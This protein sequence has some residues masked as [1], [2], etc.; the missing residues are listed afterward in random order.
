[1]SARS[2]R[3][4]KHLAIRSE[5]APTYIIA[6][7][8]IIGE[9]IFDARGASGAELVKRTKATRTRGKTQAG[10]RAPQRKNKRRD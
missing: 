1:M 9:F 4:T 10:P 3:T 5:I 8:Y 6:P 7:A 2:N